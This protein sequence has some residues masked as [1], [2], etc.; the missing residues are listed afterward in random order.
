MRTLRAMRG[1]VL[2]RMLAIT[3]LD[4]AS[5]MPGARC[6]NCGRVVRWVCTCIG[7]SPRLA[8]MCGT[9]VGCGV[10]VR[11]DTHYVFVDAV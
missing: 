4:G 6:C 11:A 5:G 7:W 8:G 9:P 2:V 10:R 3:A 1:R